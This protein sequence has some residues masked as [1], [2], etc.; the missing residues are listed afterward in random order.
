[1]K[2]VYIPLDERP[3]NTIY[4]L[5]AVKTTKDIEVLTPSID[6]LG[7]KKE[8]GNIKK[9]KNFLLNK[10]EEAD[11]IVLS[12]ET[13]VYGGLVPSRLHHLKST[14]IDEYKNTIYQLREVNPN[15][16]I[17]VSNLIMRTPRY[18][19]ND[20]EPD[21]YGTYGEEIFNYG[22][23]KDKTDRDN[24]SESEEQQLKDLENTIPRSILRDYEIRRSFNVQ[25]NKTNVK[26]LDEG[27]IDF[28]VIPQ[29]DAAEYGYTAMDQQEVSK[30]LHSQK[31]QNIMIYPGADE[32]GFSLLARAYQ[33]FHGMRLKVFPFYSSTYGQYIIPNYEDRPI[34]E[35]LKAHIMATGCELVYSS[36]EADFVL[37][38]NTPGKKMQEAWDQFSNKEITYSS[39]RHLPTFINDIKNFIKRDIPVVLADSAYSNGGDGELIQQLDYYNLFNKLVSYKAWNTNGNTIGSSIAS[40]VF[41]HNNKEPEKIIK[42]LILH[43]YEDF[44]YQSIVRMDVTDHELSELSLNYFDLKDEQD[45]VAEVVKEKMLRE[46][47]KYLSNTKELQEYDIKIDFPWNRMFEICIQINKKQKIKNK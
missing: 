42:N 11:A 47:Q 46:A 15:L 35:T 19:S 29:D 6:I 31:I 34:N 2:I 27:K 3:C 18:N 23:L 33:E 20:E 17:Y 14:D 43:F 38:Y 7:Q 26:L 44:I 21:Y 24:L 22:W 40:G 12:T 39:Y 30:A 37:A 8:P 36:D 4:P 45:E 16:K 41:G 25:I 13:L 10:A 1:M 28:L 32:V 5:E 9:I